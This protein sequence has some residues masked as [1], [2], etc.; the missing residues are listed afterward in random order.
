MKRF[1]FLMVLVCVVCTSFNTVKAVSNT[2]LQDTS[3]FTRIISKGDTGGG[4]GKYI[5]LSTIRDNSTNAHT[6]SIEAKI[7][8]VLP[9]SDLIREYMVRYDYDL[10][11]SF[12]NM[13]T[14]APQLKTRL[15]DFSLH[16]LWNIKMMESGIVGM[17]LNQQDYTLNGESKP[18]QPALKG[19]ENVTFLTPTDFDFESYHVANRVF[20]MVYGT[21]YD[22]VIR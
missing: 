7:Y 15:P 4:D 14:K 10:N 13:V 20:K 18:T 9:S 1:L 2:E 16:E 21:F 17:V 6:K 19:Y 5:E 11:L 12:A 22:D 3:R 8:V